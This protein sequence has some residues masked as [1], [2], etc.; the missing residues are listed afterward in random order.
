MKCPQFMISQF[1]F[2]FALFLCL[3]SLKFSSFILFLLYF[4]VCFLSSFQ[5]CPWIKD[6]A[7]V[8]EQPK[9]YCRIHVL[10]ILFIGYSFKIWVI[11][12]LWYMY[13]YG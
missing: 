10:D 6:I 11:H 12:F 1:Y 9:R 2:I 3:F 13:M 7:E 5:K 8:K 4:C